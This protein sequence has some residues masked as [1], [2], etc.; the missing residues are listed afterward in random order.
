MKEHHISCSGDRYSIN[1]IVT[2]I[3]ETAYELYVIAA[4]T[5]AHRL[6][7]NYCDAAP[8]HILIHKFVWHLEPS[9]DA[10]VYQ[11]A[12]VRTASHWNQ[13]TSAGPQ[14]RCTVYVHTTPVTVSG[15][16]SWLIGSIWTLQGKWPPLL[17]STVEA[18]Y[19]ITITVWRVESWISPVIRHPWMN[20]S[21]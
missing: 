10:H 16:F 9:A 5:H 17:C 11:V 20:L 21:D 18:S 3:V 13:Y 7:Q 8:Q 6:W 19:R 1:Y 4:L 2:L 15:I 14:P 12:I